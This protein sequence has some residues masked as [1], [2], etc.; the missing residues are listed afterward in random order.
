MRVDNF[1]QLPHLL[2]NCTFS[3]TQHSVIV[4][5]YCTSTV[6]LHQYGH[7]APV[8]SYC[9]GTVISTST[10]ILHRYC[11]TAPVLSCCTGT[12]ISTSTVILHRYCHTAPVLSYCTSTD[13]MVTAVAMKTS[14]LILLHLNYSHYLMSK[15][16]PGRQNRQTEQSRSLATELITDIS[17]PKIPQAK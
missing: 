7:T 10:V 14:Y 6:I 3:Y 13:V 2:I 1:S 11:H 5:S 12:V 9:T 16:H 15:Y 17:P 8:L 4:L